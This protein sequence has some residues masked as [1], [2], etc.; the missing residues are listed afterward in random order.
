MKAER[1]VLI[2]TSTVP[3]SL[4]LL[5][6]N[7]LRFLNRYFRVI[8]VSSP[9]AQLHEIAEREGVEIRP[10]ETTREITPFKDLVSLFK[11]IQLL[12]REKPVV[13]HAHSPKANLI[14]MLAAKICGVPVRIITVT[15]L[16]F[17]TLSGFS[18]RIVILLEKLACWSATHIIA[19]GQGVKKKMRENHITGKEI[20]IIGNGNING[21]D[22]DH[23]SVEKVTAASLQQ[24][25]AKLPEDG[26][27]NF[28]YVGRLVVDKGITELVTAFET[29]AQRF[30]GAR[31]II[32]GY[33]ENG[34]NEL[35]AETV[36][37][38]SLHPQIIFAGFQSDIRPWLV[39]SDVLVLPS[40]REGFPNVVLQACAMRVPV[41][42]TR[43]NGADEIIDGNNGVIID[44][45]NIPSLV[46]TMA[47]FASGV[48]NKKEMGLHAEKLVKEK[49]NQAY[50]Y[51]ALIQFYERV[52]PPGKSGAAPLR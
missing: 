22:T 9:G 19:E 20:L 45:K 52:L 41:I 43:V 48:Y 4:N 21:I 37:K 38:I 2:R 32:V 36:E 13:V 11:W 33:Y 18:R 34:I 15:G 25:K 1:P 50:L 10:L 42:V 47:A 23:W 30:P 7:Q 3:E 24:V 29:I 17:E 6:K 16:R 35:P 27:F 5:L 26:S 40:Y 46:E 31:L 49:F 8:V 12:R 28:I 44:I 51:E 14:S 39:A